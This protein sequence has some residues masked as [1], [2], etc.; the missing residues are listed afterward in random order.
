MREW[1][2]GMSIAVAFMLASWGVLL[3][4]ARRLPPGLLRDLAP[5]SSL[6]A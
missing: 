2:L 5:R 4:L 3:L 1:L 6:I